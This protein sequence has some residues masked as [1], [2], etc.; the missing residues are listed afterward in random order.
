MRIVMSTKNKAQNAAVA[1]FTTT[2]IKPVD[3][4][5][6]TNQVAAT[7][8]AHPDYP[9]HPEIQAPVAK[10]ITQAQLVGTLQQQIAACHAQLATLE[11]Q[12]NDAVVEWKRGTRIV[13]SAVEGAAGGSPTAITQWGLEVATRVA[14]T[15]STDP[16][17]NLRVGLTLKHAFT[18]RWKAIKN[19]KGYLLQIGDGTPSGWGTI[20]QSTKATYVPTGL[21]S[22]QHI[23]VRVAVIRKNGQSAWSDVLN[24]VVR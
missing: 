22:G 1:K 21:T 12:R 3:I 16:P 15:P 4:A 5:G 20:L 18:I 14:T 11:G 23:A 24:A 10:W 13:V 7:I 17:V 6:A 9:N 2:D 8:K 19:A